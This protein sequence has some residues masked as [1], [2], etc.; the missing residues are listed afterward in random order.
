[1]HKHTCKMSSSATFGSTSRTM[2]TIA[3]ILG[4]ALVANPIELLR[5]RRPPADS[6]LLCLLDWTLLS[7]PNGHQ[8]QL[9][10]STRPW[11]WLWPDSDNCLIIKRKRPSLPPVFWAPVVPFASSIAATTP[12]EPTSWAVPLQPYQC[13]QPYYEHK[14]QTS[15]DTT[16]ALCFH[17]QTQY[18]RRI[19]NNMLHYWTL[20]AAPARTLWNRNKHCIETSTM[21]PLTSTCWWLGHSNVV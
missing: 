6:C 4:S 18:N 7:P 16:A 11:S 14:T 1:M 5:K 13:H 3:E 9:P 10:F 21:R 20:T 8:F 17:Q 12:T 15:S 19:H 2:S